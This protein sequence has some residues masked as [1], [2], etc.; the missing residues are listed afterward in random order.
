MGRLARIHL[1]ST[2]KIAV[3]LQVS[4]DY[5]SIVGNHPLMAEIFHKVDQIVKRDTTVLIIRIRN[6]KR[7]DCERNTRAVIGRMAHR[8]T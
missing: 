2:T 1:R 5:G 7:T 6:R 3:V 8:R 4:G